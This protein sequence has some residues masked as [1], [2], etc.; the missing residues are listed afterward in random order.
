MAWRRKVWGIETTT[1]TDSRKMVTRAS[2]GSLA[3]GVCKAPQ[4]LSSLKW[5]SNEGGVIFLI[6]RMEEQRPDRMVKSVE[7]QN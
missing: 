1:R 5:A 6:P 2:R 4:A 3:S 7:P